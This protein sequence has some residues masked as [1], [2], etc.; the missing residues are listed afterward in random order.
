MDCEKPFHCYAEA[1]HTSGRRIDMIAYD[2]DCAIAIEA[3]K[4]GNVGHVSLAVEEDLKRLKEFSPMLSPMSE[5]SVAEDW[6]LKAT[7]RW[8]LILIGSHGGDAVL[9]AWKV[10]GEEAKTI[11]RSEEHTSELQSLMRSS[12]AV[13]C[14]KKKQ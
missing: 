8:G 4:F 10:K 2:G 14:L 1:S 6:W 7:Q 12:Y 11:L 3:K 13:F 9:N 5:S